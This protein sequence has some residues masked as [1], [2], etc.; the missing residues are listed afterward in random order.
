[1]GEEGGTVLRMRLELELMMVVL[2][3]L[4][5]G[6]TGESSSRVARRRREGEAVGE[7]WRLRS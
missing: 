3:G 7:R 6:K 1:M 2:L 4:D 5:D